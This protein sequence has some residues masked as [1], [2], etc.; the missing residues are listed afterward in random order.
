M[1]EYSYNLV[2]A[3]AEAFKISAQLTNSASQL[4]ILV[5]F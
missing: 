1:S 4:V 5:Y 3:I 2:N